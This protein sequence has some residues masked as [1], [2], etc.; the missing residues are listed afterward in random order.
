MIANY[1]IRRILRGANPFAS[2]SVAI[3]DLLFQEELHHPIHSHAERIAEALKNHAPEH[4]AERSVTLPPLPLTDN[5]KSLGSLVAMTALELMRWAGYPGRHAGTVP[6]G[7]KA[8]GD[9]AEKLFLEY[10]TMPLIKGSLATAINLI[11]VGDAHESSSTVPSASE[12]LLNFKSKFVEKQMGVEGYIREAVFRHIPWSST[13]NSDQF[14]DFGQGIYT[15]RTWK[16]FTDKTSHIATSLST[17]KHLSNAVL[18]SAGLPVPRQRL[19]HNEKSAI[20][21]FRA[22]D[23]HVVVKPIAQDYGRGVFPNLTTEDEVI[24]AFANARHYGPVI[25]EDHIQGHHH[26]LMVIDGRFLS[27]RKQI[28]A[29]ITGDGISTVK[30]LVQ[31]ANEGRLSKGWKP[32]PLDGESHSVLAMQGYQQDS[33]PEQHST[34]YLRMQGNLSTG[35]TMEIVTETVHPDNAILAIRAARALNIDVA[36][37]DFITVDITQSHL[38]VGGAICEVNVTPG[39][40]FDEENTLFDLWFSGTP[41]G[42][43]PTIGFLGYPINECFIQQTTATLSKSMGGNV[44]VATPH[45]LWTEGNKVFTSRDP[46]PKTIRMALQESNAVAALLF[47]DPQLILARG[48]HI[49]RIGLLIADDSSHT[50]D[51]GKFAAAKAILSQISDTSVSP[52]TPNT[53]HSGAN[54]KTIEEGAGVST[55]P[56]T[57]CGKSHPASQQA[58]AVA[59]DNWITTQLTWHRDPTQS[60]A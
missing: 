38:Q 32:I 1:H 52:T 58:T 16:H 37:I 33:V 8:P 44:T 50:D 55:H 34:V 28:P 56:C 48:A 12:T 20:E 23:G 4:T 59:I 53:S 39:F 18:E 24:S 25:V 2:S 6:T 7:N 17:N 36:G 11:A 31:Q 14:F 60:Q 45:D 40:I 27:A 49:D 46:S 43:I 5:H 22:L 19:V 47:F 15:R 29:H 30:H 42:R 41:C 9:M 57:L 35:G 13:A 10:F 54:Q 21:E 3:I 26:R 51:D